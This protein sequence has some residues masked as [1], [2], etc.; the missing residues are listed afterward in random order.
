MAVTAVDAQHGQTSVPIEF[1]VSC[2]FFDPP[3]P[4]VMA[5]SVSPTA[6]AVAQLLGRSLTP[7][8]IDQVASAVRGALDRETSVIADLGDLQPGEVG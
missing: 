6:D 8:E 3:G 1:E 7:A 2:N 5:V 4:L